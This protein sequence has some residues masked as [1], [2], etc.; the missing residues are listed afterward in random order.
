MSL[1]R[2][3]V[4]YRDGRAILRWLSPQDPRDLLRAGFRPFQLVLRRQD[5]SELEGSLWM[6]DDPSTADYLNAANLLFL[7][8]PGSLSWK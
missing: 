3:V 1:G 7:D 4:R 5:G 6:Q 8:E 2:A